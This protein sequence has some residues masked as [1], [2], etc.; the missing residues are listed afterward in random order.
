MPLRLGGGWWLRFPQ[1]C[2]LPQLSLSI[3]PARSEGQAPRAGC[4]RRAA[5]LRSLPAPP[6]TAPCRAWPSP[7]CQL[8]QGSWGSWVHPLTPGWMLGAALWTAWGW[9]TL[10]NSGPS[11]GFATAL[12]P[13][14]SWSSPRSCPGRLCFSGAEIQMSPSFSPSAHVLPSSVC[15]SSDSRYR[16]LRNKGPVAMVNNP[17]IKALQKR[18][19]R[20]G[21]RQRSCWD[22]SRGR[23][24][25]KKVFS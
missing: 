18:E 10:P 7:C 13:P 2:L 11:W 9:V 3:R 22:P 8:S 21:E 20:R 15:P 17:H 25:W 24:G 12:H 14:S 23:G 1:Q 6:C 5:Q 16:R 19:G 4:A